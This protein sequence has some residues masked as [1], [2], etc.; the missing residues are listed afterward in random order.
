[1]AH[2]RVVHPIKKIF[3]KKKSQ[4]KQEKVLYP[5]SKKTWFY[6]FYLQLPRPLSVTKR[7]LIDT[8]D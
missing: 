3:L 1:M 2:E 4:I 7:H 8:H 6:D 5:Q